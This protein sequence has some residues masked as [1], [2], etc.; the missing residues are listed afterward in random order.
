MTDLMA[1]PSKVEFSTTEAIIG[2]SYAITPTAP[3]HTVRLYPSPQEWE[4]Q[5]R[6]IG[7]LY[8]AERKS[9]KE[10]IEFMARVHGHHG[11]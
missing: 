2:T 4:S 8:L 7:R 9:L 1:I 10:V 11:T 5:K 6:E 3:L